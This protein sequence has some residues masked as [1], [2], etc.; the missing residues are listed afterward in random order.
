VFDKFVELDYEEVCMRKARVIMSKPELSEVLRR[1][2][3]VDTSAAPQGHVASAQ[4]TLC[5]SDIRDLA[6]V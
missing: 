1:A 5:P 4:Y 2:N 3:P 6:Q